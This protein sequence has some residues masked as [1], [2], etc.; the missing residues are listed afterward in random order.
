[1][2]PNPTFLLLFF[3]CIFTVCHPNVT[4]SLTD[5]ARHFPLSYNIFC[6]WRTTFRGLPKLPG[7]AD[8][9]LYPY[10]LILTIIESGNLGEAQCSRVFAVIG[11]KR[12]RNIVV[13][14]ERRIE[15]T[16]H[17]DSHY[18][19]FYLFFYKCHFP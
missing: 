19:F 6:Q 18:L 17:L 5:Y 2:P 8:I 9:P 14:H 4:S 15:V 7:S 16:H 11:S 3:T 12:Q 13:K 1:M 10:S